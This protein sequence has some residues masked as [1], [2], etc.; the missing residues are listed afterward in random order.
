MSK[1][2]GSPYSRIIGAITL[3]GVYVK[4]LMDM[5]ESGD[6]PDY[7]INA[8]RYRNQMNQ[9]ILYMSKTLDIHIANASDSGITFNGFCEYVKDHAAVLDSS[10]ENEELWSDG[11]LIIA[12]AVGFAGFVIIRHLFF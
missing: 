11:R 6:L 8:E 1:P 7:Y 3:C 10:L 2:S 4:R 5:E 9:V 12:A